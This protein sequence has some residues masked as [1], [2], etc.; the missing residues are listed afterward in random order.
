MDFL[1]MIPRGP[2]DPPILLLR[3][4]VIEF[5]VDDVDGRLFMLDRDFG[6]SVTASFSKPMDDTVTGSVTLDGQPLGYV[7]KPVAAAMGLWMLA[8]RVF[9]RL[10]EH[11]TE[12]VLHVEGFT[13]TDGNAGPRHGSPPTTPWPGRSP[14]TASCSWRTVTTLSRSPAGSSTSSATRCTPIG[15]P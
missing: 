11:G 3:E 9:G 10:V 6:G 4:P 13:D 7:L 12:H 14:R 15:P 8:V 5:D 2:Q 1:S